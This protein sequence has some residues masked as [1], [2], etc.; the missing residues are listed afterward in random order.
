M[1]RILVANFNDAVTAEL[2]RLFRRRGHDVTSRS[3]SSAFAEEDIDSEAYHLVVLDVSG[4]NSIVETVLAMKRQLPSPALLCVTS[5]YR[6][7]EWEF[8]LKQK[9]ARV[10][11]V[12]PDAGCL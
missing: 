8:Q 6:G 3:G 4:T 2:M 5:V 1:A 7:P 10:L 9:G 11:Y 12:V